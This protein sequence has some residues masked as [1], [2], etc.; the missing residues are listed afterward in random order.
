MNTRRYFIKRAIGA[1]ALLLGNAFIF[2][3]GNRGPAPAKKE[4]K[5]IPSSCKD[6]T[7]ISK[8]EIEKRKKLGYVEETPIAENKCSNCKLYLPPAD[9]SGCGSCTLFKGPVEA[10][11]YCAYYAPLT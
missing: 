3:C 5:H 11:G 1:G 8:E 6:L 10:E 7:G 2:S 9:A 4:E